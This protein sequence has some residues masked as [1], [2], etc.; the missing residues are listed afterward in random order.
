MVLAEL[1]RRAGGRKFRAVGQGYADGLGG[2]ATDHGVDV[3]EAR[4][5]A[6]VPGGE[7]SYGPVFA[8]YKRDRRAERDR[9][10]A[11]RAARGAVRDGRRPPWRA[12]LKRVQP[13]SRPMPPP[14]AQ[15]GVAPHPFADPGKD[16]T[17]AWAPAT[18]GMS[19]R[20]SRG[21]RDR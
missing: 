7:W 2:L 9:A 15:A 17:V 18:G 5:G 8:P 4:A 11:R 12:R 20:L 14:G 3:A 1:D 13:P 21:R 6:S 16:D 19:G 10:A